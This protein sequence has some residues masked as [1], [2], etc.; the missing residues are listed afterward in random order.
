MAS[1]K[2]PVVLLHGLNSSSE[3][4]WGEV[5]PL[6]ADHHQVY[7]PGALGHRGGPSVQ[8]RPVTMT[9][10]I[11][12]A[13]HYLDERGLDRPHLAGSSMG[14][15]MAIELAR[16]GRAATVCALSPSGLWS[17]GDGLQVGAFKRI[18]R[19]L[20]LGRLMRP[21]CPLIFRSASLRRI[22]LRDIAL[23][24][25]RLTPAQAV[26]RV[27]GGLD[28]A[29]RN[30]AIDLSADAWQI[31]PLNPLPCPITI[32]WS[33]KTHCF[34]W[35]STPGHSRSAYP[36][37]PLACLPVSAT[38]RCLT[39]PSW[40]RAPSSPSQAQRA[41]STRREPNQSAPEVA[42]CRPPHRWTSCLMSA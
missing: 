17:S 6:L 7:A 2:S 32:A 31:A 12:A 22:A 28:G 41:T 40:W 19:N 39:T 16:R 20:A 3:S 9:D 1:D 15:V 11:D 14:A 8:R 36:R 4:A 34:Q 42:R 38:N 18:R 26:E 23:H 29:A 21:A 30:V 37:P 33:R 27:N 24:G 35:P 13:E 5:V 25:D 10:V